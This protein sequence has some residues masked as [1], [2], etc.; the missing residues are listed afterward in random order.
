MMKNRTIAV[1]NCMLV[2]VFYFSAAV[3]AQSTDPV[4]VWPPL[5][6]PAEIDIY[7][8]AYCQQR[9]PLQYE[10]GECPIT[11]SNIPFEDYIVGVLE[12][13]VGPMGALIWTDEVL[14]AQAVAS[15]SFAWTNWLTWTDGITVYAGIN[16]VRQG[17]YPHRYQDTAPPVPWVR[18]HYSAIVTNTRRQYM[19]HADSAYPEHAISALF[20]A[21]NPAWTIPANSIPYLQSI[22]DPI[23][24]EY[25][26]NQGI[27]MGQQA[28]QR[29]ST[30]DKDPMHPRTH[31]YMLI[32]QDYRQILTH[33]Y[34][35]IHIDTT[36]YNNN[37]LTPDY[38]WNALRITPTVSTMTAGISYPFTLTIQNAGSYSWT[39]GDYA[40]GYE[41]RDP[42]GAVL[43]A[44]SPVPLTAEVLP[45]APLTLTLPVTAPLVTT[46][47]TY[48]LA[49]DLR[50][51]DSTW[52]RTQDP[53]YCSGGCAS[54]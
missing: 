41:W 17:Y 3:Q 13:E 43:T 36:N 7:V 26:S 51:A 14:K 30:G 52:L 42:T 49:W 48:T 37:R 32:W 9:Y 54:A 46:R 15:R 24:A 50:G 2:C 39:A 47:G 38:R 20:K 27:G 18:P 44:G 10:L 23:S 19:T 22:Y 16:D 29:W 33:F 28:M 40:I 31:L 8:R 35:G 1:L 4:D 11:E 25:G 6:M 5:N 53:P 12:Q 21:D 45:G 34:T